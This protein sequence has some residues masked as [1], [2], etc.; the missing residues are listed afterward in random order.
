VH[1]PASTRVGRQHVPQ[2][3]ATAFQ[4][5]RRLRQ[6]ALCAALVA[7]A[8]LAAAGQARA[9]NNPA[10]IAIPLLGDQ[11]AGSPYPSTIH[12]VSRGGPTIVA[13][14]FIML[15]AVTHQ[16]PEDLA[17]LLVHNGAEKYLLMSHAGGCHPL[18]GTDVIFTPAGPALPDSDAT[19]TPYGQSLVVSLSNYGTAPVFP[20]PAPAGP[21]LTSYPNTFVEGTWDLY[22]M[23]TAIGHRGV[24]AAGWSFNY[25][26]QYT[27]TPTVGIPSLIPAGAP[28]TTTGPAATYPIQFNLNAVP[29]GVKAWSIRVGVT[30]THTFPDD[31]NLV[32]E[33]PNGNKVLLMS[34]AGGSLDITNVSLTFDDSAATS[35]PDSTQI[36]AG[37][38]KPSAF[39]TLVPPSGLVPPVAL[40]APP[41]GATLGT[42]TGQDAHGIWKLWIYDDVAGDTGSISGATLNINTELSPLFSIDVPT[43]GT[44][45]TAN[46]PFLHLE[47]E[48]EDLVNSQ[49]SVSWYSMVG[50]QYYASGPM[51]QTP[52]SQVVQADIPMKKGTNFVQ[53]YV[54]NTSGVQLGTDDLDVTVNE[55]VYTLSEGATGGFFDLDVTM[56]NPTSVPAPVSISFLPEHSAPIPFATNV[57]AN[58]PVQLH[59]DDLTPGDGVST[60]VHSTDAVPLAVERTMSWDSTGYGGSGG[61]AIFPD[62][63]W[64]FAE[65]SQ[66][67]FDTF[68]LLANDGASAATANVKFLIEG[69]S[70]FTKVVAVPA[71]ARVT[72]FAGDIPNVVNTSFGLD[73]TADQPITAE[74]SMYFPHGAPR[75]FEGGHEAAGANAT[76]T[77]WFLAEG[78]TGPFFECFILLSNP[79]AGVAH[80]TLTY[81]LPDG[82]TIPQSVTVPANGRNTIDVEGVDPRLANTAVS[83]T[84]TSDIGII[85]ERS[86]YWPD[87]SLGWREAHNSVGVTDP[88]LRWS[89]SDARIGGA[90]EYQTYILLANPNPVPA[91]VQVR[92]LRAGVAA[93]TQ[94]YTLLP[95]SRLNISPG[96]GDLGAGVYSA[97]IQVLNFQ[98]IVVEKAMYWN[99]GGEVWAAG[100]G[101][102]GTPIPPPE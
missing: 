9:D 36:V 21:Y 88:A 45:Y 25:P 47:G 68:I 31:L 35:L 102:V 51:I 55:F 64:L 67:Y 76:S 72:I 7:I 3:H 84:V 13:Q 32:L 89:V 42:L 100:T 65:G 6:G 96:T 40:P 66:G 37:T 93:V 11:G 80:A 92:F 82:T 8:V 34:N 39:G 54:R 43:T 63:H 28:A 18:A 74:R 53:V 50:G 19:T 49:H 83:T 101:T 85:V 1:G 5:R 22:V 46:T 24:V 99:S 27:Y 69:G 87:I 52:G 58:S 60:I 86:M 57:A 56:A 91:E 94:N 90:R 15:H 2:A 26:T 33:A 38:F 30:M 71:H 16:C 73:I 41:Y 23:D 4:I 70:P 61:T 44:T 95:T 98:P 81:L 12:V 20:A 14:P 48:V 78:A 97:D 29:A 62:K 59:V 75:T 10:P 77:H 17:L 79:T